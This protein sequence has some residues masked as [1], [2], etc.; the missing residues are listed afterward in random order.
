M[1]TCK[2][3]P[4]VVALAICTVAEVLWVLGLCFVL[5]KF[6][7][8]ELKYSEQREATPSGKLRWLWENR[9]PVVLTCIQFITMILRCLSD[10]AYFWLIYTDHE[11]SAA[12]AV[13]GGVI[14][15]SVSG[16]L[17]LLVLLYRLESTFKH[18]AH[19]ISAG[20]VKAYKLMICLIP[21]LA[22]CA[23]LNKLVIPILDS[24]NFIVLTVFTGMVMSA[25]FTLVFLINREYISR[26]FTLAKPTTSAD[27][28]AALSSQRSVSRPSILG[29]LRQMSV[30]ELRQHS[31]TS[32][33]TSERAMLQIA[34]KLGVLAMVES[35][36]YLVLVG[37]ALM[38][39]ATQLSSTCFL[40]SLMVNTATFVVCAICSFLTF[41]R[42]SAAY[43]A[44]CWKCDYWFQKMVAYCVNASSLGVDE[45]ELEEDDT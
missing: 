29:H 15:W 44:I 32:F 37:G 23:G 4:G 17:V 28:P 18:T 30:G 14:S 11:G 10:I 39:L 35:L 21:S 9:K 34:A 2:R 6:L 33:D 3:K 41:A 31:L 13:F 8:S 16:T 20:R 1:G 36:A 7:R 43:R 38:F 27:R 19:A 5:D 40:I 12:L 26:L 42:S 22:I 25:V 24:V 45:T